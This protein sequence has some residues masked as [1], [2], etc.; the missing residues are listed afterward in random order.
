M[1]DI[2]WETMMVTQFWHHLDSKSEQ[3]HAVMDMAT[4]SDYGQSEMSYR[5]W[6][7]LRMKRNVRLLHD[8][9]IHRGFAIDQ[10]KADEHRLFLCL[11]TKQYNK[12][13]MSVL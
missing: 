11:H 9:C 12:D 10:S 2:Q 6:T 4:A 8:L 1:D 3:L 13:D 5:S 7:G